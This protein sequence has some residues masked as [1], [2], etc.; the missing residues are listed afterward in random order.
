M[1]I[2][3]R[4]QFWRVVGRIIVRS[5]SSRKALSSLVLFPT[6]IVYSGQSVLVK[7][8]CGW[9]IYPGIISIRGTSY[10]LN[11]AIFSRVLQLHSSSPLGVLDNPPYL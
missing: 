2:L 6:V 8:P 4:R 1:S 3:R 7:I 5:N 11:F 9:T 10:L